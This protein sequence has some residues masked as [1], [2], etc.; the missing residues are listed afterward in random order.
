MTEPLSIVWNFDPVFIALGSFDIRYYGVMWALAILIGAKFFDNFCKREG[1]PSSVSESIF[2]YG[3]LATI[4]GARLG[5]CL[6]Y[7]TMEYLS[8][9]W[10]IVTGFRD[11]GMASHGAA[12]G[13]LIGLWLF[14]R[15]NR[16][17]YIWSLDR[18]M[19]PVGIGGAIVRLGN[20]FNS[21]IFGRATTL[22]WGFEFV[23]SSKWMHEYAPAAVHPTQIYEALCYLLTFGILCWLYYKKDTGRRRPGVLFGIGLIGTFLTRFFIEFI[24][25]EQEAFEVDWWLDMGQWLSIPFIVLGVWMI[26]WGFSRPEMPVAEPEKPKHKRR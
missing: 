22:P 15:K 26:R 23:R 14:S 4:I 3:T 19:I 2:V 21:E 16:L 25:T 8:R 11:G 12:I 9:P 20:L 17:P 6:F 10:T 24:K 18:I 1:L 13:L 5:H 7:D